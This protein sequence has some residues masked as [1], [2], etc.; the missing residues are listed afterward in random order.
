MVR[1]LLLLL[2]LLPPLLLQLQQLLD[3]TTLPPVTTTN[4]FVVTV[5]TRQQR[6]ATIV[7]NNDKEK[8]SA[9]G[10]S[11]ALLDIRKGRRVVVPTTT[12]MTLLD[13]SPESSSSS[14]DVAAET[15]NNDIV[16][17]KDNDCDN[18]AALTND[19]TKVDD[20]TT[21]STTT[22]IPSLSPGI[23]K[24]KLL[25]IRH[26][27]SVANEYMSQFGNTWGESTFRDDPSLVDAP[28]SNNG[29]KQV[30]TQLQTQLQNEYVEF[31]QNQ[32][33]LIV[34]SPLTRC[35]QTYEYGVLPVLKELSLLKKEPQINTLALPLM[36]ERVYTASD[37]GRDVSILANEFPS[38]N[39][40]EYCTSKESC[41]WYTTE[42]P[43]IEEWR[44]YGQGQWYAV[45]G[46]P[47]EVFSRRMKS[48]DEWIQN[49]PET[50]IV[51]VAHWGIFHH[52]TDGVEW[53]NGEGKMLQWKYDI[54]TWTSSIKLIS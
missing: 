14:A 5:V 39:F 17:C 29:M 48:F 36:A 27:I 37:T 15:N 28:L 53:D 51:L 9:S 33:E 4:A 3:I 23:L 2:L 6:T 50:N 13:S 11:T 54:N 44:P 8:E 1:A 25:C 46:E 49:R 43:E 32:V 47:E 7:K 26:G 21:K 35:L 10:T 40:S 42:Y 20:E 31:L 45:P 19:P 38:V 52:L 24:K 12:T 41:W 16:I 22:S 30:Q 18:L 34:V